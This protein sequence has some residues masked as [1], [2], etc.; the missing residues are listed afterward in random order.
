LLHTVTSTNPA[1]VSSP[2]KMSFHPYFTFK[3]IF[4][5]TA[6]LL[7]FLV[8]VSYY[9]N[10]LG[11][12]DNFIPA[13]PLVTPPHIVP[14][15]YFT[16]FYAILRSCPN[17]LG[18]V[19]FM[20]AAILILFLIPFYKI[21]VNS[22]VAPLS[23]LHKISFWIFVA[24]FFILTFLGGKPATAPYVVA[25]QFFTF[26]YFAYFLVLIPFVPVL[27]RKFISEYKKKKKQGPKIDPRDCRPPDIPINPTDTPILYESLTSRGYVGPT[28]F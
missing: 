3:D 12:S 5:L 17:K 16:P 8:L 9:P 26:A 10:V 23:R 11:H 22:V 7:F 20:L 6:T 15:W 14:E 24:I 4:A 25:S 19:V 18:G 28:Y 27:E 21:P 2:D 1:Q 13:N